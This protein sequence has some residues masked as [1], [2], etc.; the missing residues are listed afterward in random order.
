MKIQFYEMP[1]TNS[2]N[3]DPLQ[4]VL[5]GNHNLYKTEEILLAYG[6]SIR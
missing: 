2:G 1:D 3:L 6:L 4:N 5:L